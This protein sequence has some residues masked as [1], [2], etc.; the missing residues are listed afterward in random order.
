MY[1]AFVLKYWRYLALLIPAAH[2]GLR[3][4]GHRGRQRDRPDRAPVVRQQDAP[5]AGRGPGQRSRHPGADPRPRPALPDPVHLQGDQERLHRNPGERD[6]PDRVGG[7]LVHPGRQHLRRGRGRPQLLSGRR[8][9]HQE[10]RPEGAADRGAASRQIPDQPLPVQADQGQ[11]HRDQGF[12]DRHR[13][14]GGRRRHPGRQDL[15]PGGG[16]ALLLPERRGLHQE[17]RP[18]GAADRNHPAGQLPHQSLP[19]QGHQEHGHQDQRRGDRP[20][21]VRRRFGH[22]GRAH[23]RQG[24][25]RPQL[26]PVRRGF[27]QERRPEGAADRDPAAGRL[28]YSSEP[29][30]DHQGRGRGDRQGRGRHGHRPGRRPDPD[31]AA[32]GAE[33]AGALELRERR[34]V[35]EERRPEGAADRRAAAGHLPHQPESVQD[36]DRAGGRHRSQQGRPGD[37]AGRHSA[38][39]A[40]IRRLSRSPATTITR[41]APPS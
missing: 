27:H 26:L 39:G 35:P 38:A 40:G 10:R 7:R 15:R 31:G 36:P 12:R 4:R 14:V 30:Q 17:R 19:V 6:R 9:V 18:E 5:G 28:P 37:R 3:V 2:P 21:R 29:L 32:A 22:S 34:G 24:G 8:G 20:G 23:L 1:L 11:R 13:R 25:A 41:T 16:G 33:R